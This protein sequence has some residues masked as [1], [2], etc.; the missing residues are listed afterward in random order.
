MNLSRPALSLVTRRAL[1][2]R[3]RNRGISNLTI[4]RTNFPQTKINTDRFSLF[5]R[6]CVIPFDCYHRYFGRL[7]V[8]RETS[9]R[10]SK[11]LKFWSDLQMSYLNY[12]FHLLV[13][14]YTNKRFIRHFSI[15]FNTSLRLW[16]FWE[17]T[18]VLQQMTEI[19]LNNVYTFFW[20]ICNGCWRYRTTGSNNN[21][22][23]SSKWTI[24][25]WKIA[26]WTYGNLFLL[27][28]QQNLR[29]QLCSSEIPSEVLVSLFLSL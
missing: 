11:P 20:C 25:P 9:S 1:G 24:F 10:F 4:L 27:C 6:Q 19:S 8:Q 3:S 5:D 18:Y 29:K 22:L 15:S 17:W 14:P 13:L 16:T 7:I 26:H 23:R 12:G 21:R 28:V 2:F